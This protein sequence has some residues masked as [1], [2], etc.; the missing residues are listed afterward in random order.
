MSRSLRYAQWMHHPH[1][2][3]SLESPQ[4]K[5]WLSDPGSMTFKL[6][7]RTRQFSVQRVQQKHASIL[8]DERAPLA[9][10][11]KARVAE[12]DVILYGDGQPV[13]FGHTVIPAGAVTSDWPFFGGL[14]ERPLGA[15]LFADPLVRRGTLQYAR[16]HP[17]HPLVRRIARALAWQHIP[18]PLHARRSLFL[19]KGGIMLVTDIFLPAIHTLMAN[20]QSTT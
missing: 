8:A 4:L 1:A 15:T 18:G 17:E 10:P 11:S 19:R 12:R 6:M 13:V 9:L 16:L 5:A 3:Q 2:A 7:A 14:G 20:K